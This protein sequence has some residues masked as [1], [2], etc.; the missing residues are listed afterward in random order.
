MLRYMLAPDICIYVLKRRPPHLREQF[1]R[2]ADE[3][4][5]ST[6]TLA[7]LYYGVEKSA[8]QAA[9]RQAVEGFA[10]RLEVLQF[11]ASAAFHY[12]Q[13]RAELERAGL[14][15]GPYDMMIGAHARSEGLIL[16]TNNLREF[17]RMPGVRVENWA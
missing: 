4:S 6:I 16:V 13:V 11:S 12:G 3:L 7:E 9:N 8:R 15:C 14:P 1:D 2:L 5:I 17:G 10:A